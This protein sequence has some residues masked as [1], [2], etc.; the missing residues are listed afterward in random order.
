MMVNKLNHVSI[1]FLYYFLIFTPFQFNFLN[2]YLKL[3]FNTIINIQMDMQR[4]ENIYP[5]FQETLQLVAH[6]L[7]F[8]FPVNSFF[9]P[10]FYSDILNILFPLS[11]L[12]FFQEEGAGP[13]VPKVLFLGCMQLERTKNNFLATKGIKIQEIFWMKKPNVNH[14]L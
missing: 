5:I 9:L 11:N 13:L 4:I 2:L 1:Q 14:G 7:L 8:L 10:K 12:P 6:V 3:N